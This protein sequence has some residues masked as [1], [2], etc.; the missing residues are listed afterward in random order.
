ML[1]KSTK[2]KVDRICKRAIRNAGMKQNDIARVLNVLN[3]SKCCKQ[4]YEKHRESGSISIRQG[5]GLH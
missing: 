4:T 5:N 3:V 1:E 2:N